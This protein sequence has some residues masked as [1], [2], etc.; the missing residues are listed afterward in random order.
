MDVRPKQKPK[1]RGAGVGVVDGGAGKT[2]QALRQNKMDDLVRSAE[3]SVCSVR[4]AQF[5]GQG[6]SRADRGKQSA[7]IGRIITLPVC[8]RVKPSTSAFKAD[9]RGWTASVTYLGTQ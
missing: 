6:G 4:L 1:A 5:F 7:E 9:A 2:S 3:A 8:R